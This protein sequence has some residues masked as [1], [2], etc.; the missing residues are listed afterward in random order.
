MDN[1]N[2]DLSHARQNARCMA[3]FSSQIP[4]RYIP[5][6]NDVIK[7]TYNIL[8]QNSGEWRRGRILYNNG[9]YEAPS[10][11]WTYANCNICTY[12]KVKVKP[13]T[14]YIFKG[15]YTND[16]LYSIRFFIVSFNQSGQYISRVTYEYCE[17]GKTFQTDS[18]TYY[19]MPQIQISLRNS[20]YELLPSI[21]TSNKFILQEGNI[22]NDSAYD[23][24]FI[25]ANPNLAPN[26]NQGT[27]NWSFSTD[28]GTY[29]LTNHIAGR[30]NG[31]SVGGVKGIKL[32]LT[33]LGSY[34]SLQY[35]LDIK[36]FVPYQTVTLS[37]MIFSD[38]SFTTDAY[39]QTPN[40]SYL[41]HDQAFSIRTTAN[42]W[43]FIER[44]VILKS[45]VPSIDTACYLNIYVPSISTVYIANLKIE[46]G[47]LATSYSLSEADLDYNLDEV[48]SSLG[49]NNFADMVNY[50]KSGNTIVQGGYIR[51][52]MIHIVDP[53]TGTS[54]ALLTSDGY[55]Y[56]KYIQAKSI[57]ANKIDIED[58][59]ASSAFI[60]SLSGISLN[61]TKGKIGPLTINEN[62]LGVASGSSAAGQPCVSI[63]SRY[64]A[65]FGGTQYY[66]RVDAD[67]GGNQGMFQVSMQGNGS[68]ATPLLKITNWNTSTGTGEAMNVL[69][70]QYFKGGTVLNSYNSNTLSVNGYGLDIQSTGFKVSITNNKA[71]PPTS[72]SSNRVVGELCCD[73]SVSGL[74]KPVYIYIGS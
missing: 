12:R 30:G 1:G 57:T 62:Y 28:T 52:N 43:E 25:A 16:D 33:K 4:T 42:Q 20:N 47:P 39:I 6:E 24:P 59:V 15:D 14:T 66:F 23:N 49:Y 7:G 46:E 37:M 56:G 35:K 26:T 22:I 17:N 45:T 34:N 71:N 36:K 63:G 51:A 38:K 29:T 72:S 73:S 69:G 2:I 48:S 21:I 19:I 44:T 9:A 5:N 50:A 13:N 65:V 11:T 3:K 31:W 10:G 61:F 74:W 70:K 53:S 40:A 54:G 8:P 68:L 32:S 55:I 67:S 18:S 64:F 58:L 60:N 27:K 41:W